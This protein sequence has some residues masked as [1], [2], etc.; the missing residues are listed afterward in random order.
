MHASNR[1]RKREEIN[2]TEAKLLKRKSVHVHVHVYVHASK[3]EQVS[4]VKEHSYFFKLNISLLWNK[5]WNE[6]KNKHILTTGKNLV[7]EHLIK[8]HSLNVNL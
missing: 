8:I 1:E 5:K 2:V 3:Y 6:T 4:V 7:F